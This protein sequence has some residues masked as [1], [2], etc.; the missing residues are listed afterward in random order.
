MESRIQAYQDAGIKPFD[1]LHL[2]SAV[3]MS[4]DYFCTTD[5][6]LLRKARTANTGSTR[7]VNPTELADALNL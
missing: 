5:D 4:A 3:A 2:A 6:R 1:A 7:V